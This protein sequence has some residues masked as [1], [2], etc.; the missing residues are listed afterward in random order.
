MTYAAGFTGG[1]WSDLTPDT[2]DGPAPGAAALETLASAAV[3]AASATVTADAYY[4]HDDL[5]AT[6]TA[7]ADDFVT[8]GG[9]WGPSGTFGTSGGTVTW[10]LAGAGLS[11][12]SPVPS[13]FSG[14][15]VS[16]SK[17]LGFDFL[18]VLTQAFTAWSAVANINFVQVADGGGNLGAGTNAMIR[19]GGAH[20]DGSPS[21]S[22]ILARAFFPASAGNPQNFSYS[23]DIVFDSDEI[24]FWSPNSFLAVAT[25]E[26]GHSIGLDHTSVSGQLMDPFYDPAIATPQSDDIAGA[27][28]IYGQVLPILGDNGNNV[29][30]G[31]ANADTILGLGG[32]DTLSGL[33]GNDTLNGGTGNDFID[34]GAGDDTAVYS[35]NLSAYAV[36]DLGQR[37][38]TSG[39]DGS[40][41]V[42]AV[43]HLRF[44]DGTIHLNDGSTL[45]DTAFYDRAY[46]D[47][48]RAGTDARL[49]Y[50]LF[51]KNEGRDPNAFFSTDWYL[52]LS[53]DARASGANPLDHY[54]QTGWRNGRDPAPNFDTTLY[55]KNNSDV[56]AAGVDPLEHYLQFGRAEG[57]AIYQAVGPVVF[58]FDAEYYLR[59]NSD[60][61]HSGV[62]P[63]AHFNN[64][65]WR[66]GRNPNALFDTKG[67]LAHYADVA[68]SGVNPLVHYEQFGWKEGRDPSAQF[69]TTGYLAANPDIAAAGVNPLDHY[70][71]FGIYEG[72]AL[73]NDG[74]WG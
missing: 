56:A 6:I 39:T 48:F 32:N 65:G 30:T 13:L 28:R 14:T 62:D 18:G 7:S 51:G 10:S 21:G 64:S 27:R 70:L 60:V 43:E 11:N 16:L 71:T 52:A 55:L 67:Y 66:E 49:H 42:V 35:G 72:R 69:D 57:R 44:S 1:L 19:I 2:S 53:P 29:L 68:A 33:G 38:M 24:N 36:A 3:R 20:I 74:L 37:I 63:L 40:D 12:G 45:F 58:G 46:S 5:D 47:V 17:F 54:H 22:S 15:T 9:K 25:H 8:T 23:G 4:Y 26:I 61:L 31:T 34:G 59:Q 50:E 73:G 41:T